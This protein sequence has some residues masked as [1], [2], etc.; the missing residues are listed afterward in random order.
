[1]SRINSKV[2]GFKGMLRDLAKG[3]QSD[4]YFDAQNVRIAATDQQSTFAVTNEHGNEV[5]F[6]I[7]IPV[8]NTANTSIDYTVIDINKSL[9]YETVTSVIP[10]CELEVLFDGKVSGTQDI[11]G[12]KEMRDSAIII[13]TDGNGFDCFWELTGLNTG[14]FDLELKYMSNLQLSRSNPI[15]IKY[16]YENSII[17]KIYFIDGFNQLRFMNLRQ[18]TINGDTRNLIDVEST[19]ID[20]VSTFTL[21]QPEIDDVVAGGSHTAGMIQYAYGLYVLNGSQ[22]TLSP[23][24][25]LE[26][27]DKGVGQGG[28]NVNEA[29]G[30]TVIVNI[31]IIDTSFSH[32]KIYAVKY[33]SFN[34]K[35]QI[36]VIM[37]R[38]IDVFTDL[39]YYDDGSIISSISLEAFAFLGSDPI[40]PKHIETKDSR[41]FPINIKEKEFDVD[42][43]TRVY[44]HDNGGVAVVAE[45]MKLVN[46]VAKGTETTISSF[47]LPPKHDAINPDYDT[48]LYQSNGS[49]KGAEGEFFKVTLDTSTLSASESIK[50]RFFKDREIYRIGI[51]FYNRR[52]QTSDPKWMFDMK[53]PSGNLEGNF[54]KIKINIKASFYTWLNTASNFPNPDDKPV[55]YRILRADRQ[56]RDRTIITQGI[57]NPMVANKK[58]K[59]K[60]TIRQERIDTCDSNETSKMPSAMRVFKTISPFIECKDYHELSWTTVNDTTSGQL[61]ANR[62]TETYKSEKGS[63]T[64]AQTFQFNKMMQMFSPEILFAD[65]QLDSGHLL[66]VVGLSKSDQINNWATET[67]PNTLMHKRESKFDNGFTSS[68]IGVIINPINGD[69][70]D[71]SDKG[72]YGPTNHDINYATQ[73]MYR[74]FKGIFTPNNGTKIYS[75]Y[76]SPEIAETGADFTEYNGDGALKYSNHLKDFLQDD[77]RNSDH[78]GKDNEIQILGMNTNGAKCAV[79]VE[80][81]DNDSLSSRLSIEDIYNATGIPETNGALICEFVKTENSKYLGNIYGGNSFESK[82]ISSYIG[83]GDY[84]DILTNDVLI[85]SPGDTYVQDFTFTKLVKDNVD[86]KSQQYNTILEIVSIKLETTIDLKNRSDIAR[87]QWDNRWQPLFDDYQEYNRVYSQQS[88]LIQTTDPG[89]KFKKIKEFDTRIMASFEKIPGEN[90]DSWTDFLQNES[91]DID[92]QYGPINGVI[93]FK[94]EIYVLQD[95]AVAMIAINPRV[96]V[97]GNDGIAVQLGIGGLLHDYSYISTKSGTLNK[98]SVIEGAKA[99]YYV[100]LLNKSIMAG[101]GSSVINLSDLHGFHHEMNNVLNYK[102][103][104]LDNPGLST[105]ISTG[106]NSVNKDIYFSFK[107]STDSFTIAYNEDDKIKGFTSYYSYV[108]GFYINQGS[109]LITSD[110]DMTKLWNHF[111]GTRN[112]FYGVNHNSSITFNVV[113]DSGRDTQFNNAKY[114]MEMIDVSGKELINSSLTKIRLYNDYQDSGQVPLSLRKNL[115]KKFRQWE[116][117]FPRNAGTRDRIRSPWT[118]IEFTLENV[119]GRKMVMHDITIFYTEH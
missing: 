116:I 105:G 35:P 96:Q 66:N 107:M 14:D 108:P 27:L 69:A 70:G 29:V 28:A 59:E 49:T 8:F 17:E 10:R 74:S 19:A 38:E 48:Y 112:S 52:G 106:F 25:Q 37:D 32:I 89:F 11:V 4:R 101:D 22:T 44:S 83:I 34:Q 15:Q 47:S 5:I 103:L 98:W 6:T 60:F 75:I 87:G 67:H 97:P 45:N 91:M 88:N 63:D 114:K 20:T 40:I 39:K 111:A 72:F 118:F 61:K 41:L 58:H 68:T 76:G 50:K 42:I 113:S 57:I 77:F 9:S 3:K 43:D 100:D 64:R 21:S 33:T 82:S 24:S 13:T 46:G 80:G 99:F 84:Q 53:A 30:K 36:S 85:D 23:L 26:P 92:G 115:F 94:D 2:L 110:P 90:I 117:K 16:N 51:E 73:Q 102:D 65:I 1:M 79:F 56:I 78:V 55:G 62:N 12:V 86:K 71:L 93:N 18:S 104:V 7:P 95:S 119:D 81:G 31:P 109:R 54:N